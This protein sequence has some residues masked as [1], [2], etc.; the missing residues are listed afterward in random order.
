MN[1]GGRLGAGFY[2]A[3]MLTGSGA[4]SSRPAQVHRP[5]GP[6]RGAEAYKK[7]R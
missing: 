1:K 6:T 7:R 3:S 2:E 4:L 5:S